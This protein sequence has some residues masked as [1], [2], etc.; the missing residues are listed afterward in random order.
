MTVDLKNKYSILN[1]AKHFFS[2]GLQNYLVF[3]Y[4]TTKLFSIFGFDN[5][6]FVHIERRN[7]NIWVLGDR[8]TQGLDHSTI[9]AETKYPINF[10]ESRKQFVRVWR[11]GLSYNRS[12][13]FY[14]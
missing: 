4:K 3:L 1:G 13:V 5:T 8:P 7:K 2:N 6:S 12:I 11:H 14:M 10:T 9:T